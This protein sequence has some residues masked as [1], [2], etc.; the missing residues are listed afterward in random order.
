LDALETRAV[1]LLRSRLQNEK[2]TTLSAERSLSSQDQ[3]TV[4]G[5]FQDAEDRQ[6]N[7]E[8]KFQIKEDKIPI[9]DWSVS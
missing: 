9:A 4:N 5:I 6:R 2:L 7:F 1:E 3:I 8:M